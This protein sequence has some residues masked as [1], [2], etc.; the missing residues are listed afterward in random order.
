MKE[1][2]K[3]EKR[4]A[5]QQ[6][7]DEDNDDSPSKKDF[8]VS[9][10]AIAS[11]SAKLINP[12]LVTEEK[13]TQTQTVNDEEEAPILVN[14]D[15]P[16]LK[17]VLDG[18]DVLLEVLDARNPLPFRNMDLE[19]R[20]EGKRILLVLNKIGESRDEFLVLDIVFLTPRFTRSVSS[21]SCYI[22]VSVPSTRALNIPFQV[23]YGLLARS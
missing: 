10:D 6:A 7:V 11:L 19:K 1:K 21:G 5:R 8:D 3:E 17:A 20:M 9:S 15:L 4:L 12:K 22:V 16:N 18:S 23:G 2:R 13:P 14:R